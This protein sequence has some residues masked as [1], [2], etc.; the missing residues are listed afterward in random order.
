MINQADQK[1]MGLALKLAKKGLGWTNPHPMVGAVIVKNG[2]VIAK[3]YHHKFGEDHAEMD[4]LKNAKTDVGGAT[5]YVTLEPCHLPY[6]LHGPRV[7]CTEIIG[8]AGIK[9]VHIAALDSNPEV[10][11]AGRK[12]LEKMRVKTTLGALGLEA[13]K[14]N[15]A[16]HHFMNKKRPFVAIQFGASLDGKIATYTGDSKWINNEKAR[17]FGH[18]LRG[19]YQAILVGINT[20]IADDPNLGT[21]TKGLKD[22]LRIILDPSLKISFKSQVLMDGNALIITT[23]QAPQAKLDLLKNRG[24]KV[25]IF[26]GRKIP[27]EDLLSKLKELKIISVF[28]EGGGTTLGHFVDEKLVDKVYAFYGPVIIGGENAVSAIGGKGAET[29]K[30]A[31]H[32]ENIE[33]KRFKNDFLISGLLKKVILSKCVIV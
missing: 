17:D 4:A 6:D 32:L 26:K 28:V 21:R 12:V 2:K 14:L 27:V 29:L 22:P 18:R 31:L 33:I 5:M 25:L 3:G 23:D 30:Q 19:Y 16:Y 7:P 11:G 13:L 9:T 1:F 15:E 20:V 8:K 10:V 24:I